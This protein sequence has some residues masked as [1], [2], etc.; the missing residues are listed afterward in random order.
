MELDMH[1]ISRREFVVGVAGAGLS[2]A[3]TSLAWAGDPFSEMSLKEALERR[4]STRLFAENPVDESTLKS[5]LWSAMGINRPES[6]GR[7]APSWHS[8]YGTDVY[9]ADRGGIRRFNPVDGSLA[10]VASQ[11]IRG[12]ASPQPFVATA[13]TVLVYVADLER[14]Y[15]AAREEQIQAVHVDAAIIAQNVYLFCAAAGLG[16]CLVGGADRPG[17]A[18]IL[19]LP[20]TQFVTFVQPVGH[21]KQAT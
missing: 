3:T 13:P 11:D 20:E 1:Q 6:G 19:K 14:M 7:T 4:R 9:V 8:S 2:G 15:K 21:P 12:K 18:S 10:G 5:L 17:L 16:T